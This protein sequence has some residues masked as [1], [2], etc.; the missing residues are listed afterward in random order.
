MYGSEVRRVTPVRKS[1]DNLSVFAADEERHQETFRFSPEGSAFRRPNRTGY[2]L[3]TS[4]SGSSGTSN[5]GSNRPVYGA[6]EH[7]VPFPTPLSKSEQQRRNSELDDSPFG[8]DTPFSPDPSIVGNYEHITESPNNFFHEGSFRHGQGPPSPDIMGL[9]TQLVHSQMPPDRFVN[10]F[11][12]DIGN[13]PID[14]GAVSSSLDFESSHNHNSYESLYSSDNNRQQ[15]SSLSSQQLQMGYNRYNEGS[16]TFQTEGNTTH[17]Q[18][19]FEQHA[20]G[21]SFESDPGGLR[22]SA[23]A[24][25]SYDA[26]A[27]IY[28][29]FSGEPQILSSSHGSASQQQQQ[30]QYLGQAVSS[31]STSHNQDHRGGDGGTGTMGSQGVAPGSAVRSS[32]GSLSVSTSTGSWVSPLPSPQGQQQQQQH[33]GGPWVHNNSGGGPMEG[34]GGLGGSQFPSQSRPPPALYPAP[35]PLL[36]SQPY[37]NGNNTL[38]T[39]YHS[40]PT[41]TEILA[42]ARRKQ[43]AHH[44][45]TSTIDTGG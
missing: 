38:G 25:G 29:K 8:H 12:K 1:S 16:D 3:G 40:E 43:A 45:T 2:P 20:R 9:V 22:S 41:L 37:P 17:Y 24:G 27:M 39:G 30:Q 14:I 19:G 35:P 7:H 21:V 13:G 6:F 32:S 36:P 26:L 11:G 28:P 15:S 18:P 42:E 33:L 10:E 5:S 31:Q 23:S 4:S 44:G 34:G